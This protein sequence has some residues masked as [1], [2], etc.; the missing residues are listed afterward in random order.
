M[1]AGWAAQ[2]CLSVSSGA[3]GTVGTTGVMLKKSPSDGSQGCSGA[4]P[5]S[6]STDACKWAHMAPLHLQH[7]REDEIDHQ[8]C[9]HDETAQQNTS[10]LYCGARA[11]LKR[12]KQ[13]HQSDVQR[14]DFLTRFSV[15][16]NFLQSQCTSSR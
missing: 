9:D 12:E 6:L 13:D 2:M 14:V 16:C 8:G 4:A 11:T 10:C 15:I 7:K 5:K 1:V 3:D